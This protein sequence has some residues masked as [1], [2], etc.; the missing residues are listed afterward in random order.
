[1]GMKFKSLSP[2]QRDAKIKMTVASTERV[3]VHFY[4]YWGIS[5]ESLCAGDFYEDWQKLFVA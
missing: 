5:L 2:L 3:S 4:I 1:M